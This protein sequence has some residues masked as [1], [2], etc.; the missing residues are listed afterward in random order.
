MNYTISLE[1]AEDIDLYLLD[2]KLVILNAT[3]TPES[4]VFVE[5]SLLENNLYY[6][7]IHIYAE[8]ATEQVLIETTV[9]ADEKLQSFVSSDVGG[10]EPVPDTT[11]SS[12]NELMLLLII[13]VTAVVI[14]LGGGALLVWHHKN[15]A[16]VLVDEDTKAEYVMP[17]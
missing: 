6:I 13:C 11:Q 14:V 17:V 3:G 8:D 1:E 10:D 15:S 12:E 4:R 9:A 5:G 16:R 7:E 2:L